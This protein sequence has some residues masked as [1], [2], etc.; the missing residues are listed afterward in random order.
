V[1]GNL[2]ID[3]IRQSRD[4][5]SED[6]RR[7]RLLGD[8]L[9]NGLLRVR[10]DSE[11]CQLKARLEAENLYLREEIKLN[12]G[13]TDIVGQ[14]DSIKSVLNQVEQVAPTSASVLILGETGTGKE[15]LARAI[16]N[17]SP[18]RERPLIV[19]NCA[20]LN[21]MLIESDLFGREKGAY[22]GAHAKQ[23]GRF[24]IADGSTIFLDEI[25]EMPLE[26]Q[27][28]L[29]RVLQTGEFERLGS[30]RT[31]RVDVRVIAA[32]NKDL[33]QAVQD[34]AFRQD[35]Y[36]RLCVFPIN[37]PS[38]RDRCEDI[39]LLVW[40]FIEEFT[41]SIGKVINTVPRRTM[42]QLQRYTWPGNIRELR[43]VIERAVI[44]S[45]DQV[46]RVVLPEV[47]EEGSDP[48]LT[49]EENERRHISR[50]LERAG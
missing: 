3:M 33:A 48:E 47:E 42:E 15:L 4:W 7:L 34:G 14:S 23:V 17:Q 45:S 18:R 41:A 31:L 27:A 30:P 20:A 21:A 24:E 22:T 28:K 11:I 12:Y 8:M 44:M 19:A 10:K 1:M 16:H 32:T 46:L 29:L 49:L 40:A 25:G 6:V 9:G 38:L 2:G 26:L 35:L 13:Y 5:T 39:P 36:Y 50:V 43:N 37:V